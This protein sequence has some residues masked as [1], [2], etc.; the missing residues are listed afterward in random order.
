MY[1]RTIPFSRGFKIGKKLFPVTK[2]FKNR[3]S[4]IAPA[5]NMIESAGELYP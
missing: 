5:S 2:A 3:L 1:G 4:L